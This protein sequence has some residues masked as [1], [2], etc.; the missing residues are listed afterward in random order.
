MPA[1]SKPSLFD[2]R[3]AP[4]PMVRL[5]VGAGALGVILLLWWIATLGQAPEDRLISPVILPSP[6]EVVRSFPSLVRDRALGASIAANKVE[7][8]R[9]SV[10]TSAF[11]SPSAMRVL[12]GSGP[13]AENSGVTTLP[14]RSAPSAAT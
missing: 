2:L 9:A 12:I 7:G 5:L 10:V 1:D 6:D 13:N 4:S 8:V 3:I 11:A 14:L